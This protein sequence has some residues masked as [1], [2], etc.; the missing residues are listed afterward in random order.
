MA[1]LKIYERNDTDDATVISAQ[2][3]TT[4]LAMTF[5]VGTVGTNESHIL[6]K[7]QLSLVKNGAPTGNATI[8]ITTTDAAGKPDR[9]LATTT[10]D[11]STVGAAQ[12]WIDIESFDNQ[13]TFE[14]DT[15]YAIVWYHANADAANYVKW[16]TDSNSGYTGGV[17]VDSIDS[18]ETWT[19]E[20][21]DCTFRIYA[22]QWDI[23]LTTY[24]EVINKAGA[25]VS[26]NATDAD[27]VRIFAKQ[28]EGIVNSKTRKD[29][30]SVITSINDD[31]SGIISAAVSSLAAIGVINY[32][33]STIGSLAAERRINTLKREADELINTI[34]D[35]NIQTFMSNT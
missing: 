18:G 35:K 8:E 17:L 19:I 31:V 3:S 24:L 7:I 33:T 25:D 2:A 14:K 28:A 22:S 20:A 13:V 32:D 9:V 15:K 10:L 26:S 16:Y 4:R 1:G 11:T 21:D 5:T 12:S 34:I 29:W 6:N 23:D 30:N 27:V